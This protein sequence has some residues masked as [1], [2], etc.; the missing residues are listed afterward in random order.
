MQNIGL[1]T[2][3]FFLTIFVIHYSPTFLEKIQP[4]SQGYLNINQSRQTSYFLIIQILNKFNIDLIIFQNVFLSLSIVLLVSLI[5]EKTNIFFSL[6]GYL[7][8]VSN[9]YYTS[10]S[11]T[12]LTE[13]IFF[14][15]FNFAIIFFFSIEKKYNLFFFALA[16]GL[17]ASFKPIGIPI[18][19]FLISV[20]LF[21]LKKLGR[22]SLMLLLFS[23]PS[24]LESLTFYSKFDKRETIF[25]ISVI[26]KLFLLSGKDSFIVSN[27]PENLN[28]L[29]TKSKVEFQPIHKFLDNLDNIFLKSELL[30]DYEVVAQ[31]QALDFESIKKIDFDKR[32]LTDNYLK[33]LFQI[34]EHNLY[35][36]LILSFHHYIGNW[37]IGSKVRFLDDN[38]L[39]IPRYEELLKSSGPMQ[40]PNLFLIELAQLLFFLLFFIVTIFTFFFILSFFRIIKNKIS[41]EDAILICLLQIYLLL[42]CLTNVSTPRYLMLVYPLVILINMRFISLVKN[43]FIKINK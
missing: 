34:F 33:I 15:L 27:Y 20:S 29:L 32:I 13:S 39:Q 2:F 24:I 22:I 11:K 9:I 35:D 5:R 41:Y 36:Y 1:K 18:S 26:G 43:I 3:L 40:L 23:F 6:V 16:C 28:E 30:A 38:K 8:I 25:K 19:L 14:S 21:R 10:F 42:I 37:S 4:D 7:L 17:L 12:I 31:Y